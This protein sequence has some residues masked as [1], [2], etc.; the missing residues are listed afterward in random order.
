M[1]TIQEKF[2]TVM[3]GLGIVAQEAIQNYI[4][5]KVF[6]AVSQEKESGVHN[7]INALIEI[8]ITDEERIIKF[9]QKYSD[10]RESEAKAASEEI[11]TVEIPSKS[12]VDY[13]AKQ[14][15]T[16]Q[17]IK[18]FMKSNMVRIKLRHDPK[19]ARLKPAEI[20]KQ[21]KNNTKEKD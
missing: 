21:L 15:Y 13:L 16:D 14:G 12:L 8:G 9:L 4:D 20:V 2:F 18:N 17:E 5:E 1:S 6:Q 11:I 19:L 3:K 7:A 10:M